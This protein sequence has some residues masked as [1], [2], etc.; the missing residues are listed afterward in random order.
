MEYA[1]P[2]VFTRVREGPKRVILVRFPDVPEALTSGDDQA[3][4]HSEALDCLL[5]ALEGYV[6]SRR[7]IPRPSRRK[8][9]AALLRLPALPAAKLALYQAMRAADVSN[10]ALARRLEVTEA[11]V[12]RLLDLRHRSHI[13]Q[14]EA[15]LAALGRQLVVRAR[16]AA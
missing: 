13:S 11:V 15:A 3:D 2:V 4:A 1:Y 7:P 5:A 12:R 14:V 9:G 8:R 10:V 16:D 6:A